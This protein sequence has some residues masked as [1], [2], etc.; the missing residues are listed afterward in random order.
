MS[1]KEATASVFV[2]HRFAGGWKIGLIWH[3]RLES[4]MLP[5]GHVEPDEN[6]AEAAV[7]EVI[8]ETGL[9]VTLV[10]GPSVPLPA[11]FPHPAVPAPW[12]VAELSVAADR[13][14][15]APHVHVDHLYVGT[16]PSAEPRSEPVHPFTWFDADE[17]A[18]V[19]HMAEDSR[20]QVKELF[21][22]ID[23]ISDVSSPRS[24]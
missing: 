24:G 11:A 10:Q 17:V 9:V 18:V 6:P 8:E 4:W 14:T 20:I 19:E 21:E 5:G 22:V 23:E 3:P 13:H 12:R 15:T 2:F 7:R 16:A 1:V